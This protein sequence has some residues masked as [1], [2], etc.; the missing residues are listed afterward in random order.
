MPTPETGL[1]GRLLRRAATGPA[2]PAG[3]PAGKP[4]PKAVAS[5]RQRDVLQLEVEGRLLQIQRLRD[6]RCRRMR[7]VVDERGPRLSMPL[8]ASQAAAEA[9]VRDNGVW[10]LAQLAALRVGEDGHED[11][12]QAGLTT[13]LPLLGSERAVHWLP[14]RHTHVLLADDG[15]LAFHYSAQG[16]QAALAR[17]LGDFY[18]AQ[19]RALIG[20]ETARWLPGLPRA[21]RRFVFKQMS[22]RW[23]SLAPDATVALD[24]SLVL[25]PPA[26]LQYVLVHELCHLLQANHSP[27]FWAEVSARVPDWPQQRDWLGEH[28]RR[29]KYRLRQLL[30]VA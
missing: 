8:R 22:S 1:L 11:T 9:F 19:A 23:G 26:A 10:L 3:K 28:G 4:R 21:P 18:L 13:R 2:T 20:P 30:A 24:L 6:A 14:A 12:L 27:A 15:S 25:A 7:L 16:G 29:L 5:P 17:A